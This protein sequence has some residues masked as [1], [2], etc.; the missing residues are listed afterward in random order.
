[1]FRDNVLISL[2]HT[3][4]VLGMLLRLP[5]LAREGRLWKKPVEV[6]VE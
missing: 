3:Q 2:K 4:L 5:V 6:P 1:M